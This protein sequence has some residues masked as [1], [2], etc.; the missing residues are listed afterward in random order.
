MHGPYKID[1]KVE[2]DRLAFLFEAIHGYIAEL[3][4][5]LVSKTKVWHI[6]EEDRGMG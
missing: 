3:R 5:N 1:I 6:G 4:E 2:P